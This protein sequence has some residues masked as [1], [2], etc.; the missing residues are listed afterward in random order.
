MWYDALVFKLSGLRHLEGRTRLRELEGGGERARRGGARALGRL[1]LEVSVAPHAVRPPERHLGLGCVSCHGSRH[2][3]HQT[4]SWVC[5]DGAD[6]KA[7]AESTL[8]L[9]GHGAGA[10]FCS[11]L[12]VLGEMGQVG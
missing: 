1:R 3:T 10:P 11:T 8:R 12:V 9:V 7:A 4:L 5:A 6:R 2:A